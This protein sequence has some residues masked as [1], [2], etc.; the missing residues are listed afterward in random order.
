MGQSISLIA[1]AA[2][3]LFGFVA[4][5]IKVP[6]AV[7]GVLLASTP[8]IGPMVLGGFGFTAVGPA[9][10]SS[11]ALWQATIGNVVAGSV[12]AWCQSAAMGGLA[13]GFNVASA[14]GAAIL[15]LAAVGP[16][17]K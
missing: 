3:D 5:G 13:V 17:Q 9:A 12:F 7:L 6:L 11:A 16:C 2:R 14:A 15:G 8:I 10:G 1:E 4:G